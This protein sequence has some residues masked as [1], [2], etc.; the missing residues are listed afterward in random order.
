[1][2]DKSLRHII[3]VSKKEDKYFAI[4]D[5]LTAAFYRC[6]LVLSRDWEKLA[7]KL[8]QFDDIILGVDTN[9]LLDCALTAHL[10]DSFALVSPENY[11]HTPN[12]LLLVIPNAVMHEVEQQANS[13]D[14]RGALIYWGRRGYR[15]LEEI[16]ELD[17]SRDL[18]GLSLLLVGEANPT[19]DTRIELQ[20]I[21]EDFK[22]T[23]APPVQR[24][25]Y[26]KSSTGDTII[27]DQFKSF[28]R[29][30]GFHKGIFF[31]TGDK[32]NAALAEAEGLHSIYY[33]PP[34]W[35]ILLEGRI[36]PPTLQYQPELIT[37]SVPFSKLIYEL[38]VQFGVIQLSWE[39][40][41]ID[42]KC[43]D[44]GE[45]LDPWIN[46]DL[47]IRD[48]DLESLLQNYNAVG[49]FSLSYIDKEWKSLGEK[50]M[51]SDMT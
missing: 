1:M 12:W 43:D 46:R 28:L 35:H 30:I 50:L 48:R 44:R 27:R 31:L 7:G 2:V 18:A 21:R 13:R 29:Q 10:L 33:A 34:S 26:Q 40:G 42:I 4:L 11:I 32:S 23:V 5:D 20:G 41:K 17:R 51:G 8:S 9:I 36:S 19:L 3:G 15:A 37:I 22:K 45:S 38:A 47:I 39:G 24:G 49:K 6:G 16:L 14:E 25:L